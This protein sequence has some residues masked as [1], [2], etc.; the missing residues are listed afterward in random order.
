MLGTGLARVESQCITHDRVVMIVHPG[1]YMHRGAMG[2]FDDATL[3]FLMIV[4][5]SSIHSS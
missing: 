4:M 1:R 5:C 3:I 2:L